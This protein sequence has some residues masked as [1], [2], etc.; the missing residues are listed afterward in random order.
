MR[1]AGFKYLQRHWFQCQKIYYHGGSPRLTAS[2]AG[3]P[4]SL[5]L[6]TLD[7][8]WQTRWAKATEQLTAPHATQ[9]QKCYVLPM[10]PYPSGNLHMGHLRVYTISDVLARCRRMQGYNVLHPIGWDAFGLPAENAAVERGVD[11]AEWTKQNIRKMKEQLCAMGV[12]FDWSREFMTCDPSFYQHTQRIFLLLHERGLAYQAESLVNYDPID[13]TV[14]ANEQVDAAGFSWRSGAKVEKIMLK[15]WFLKITDF[16]EKL[17]RDLDI[18]A[19]DNRWPERVLSMQR[20][21]LGKSEGAR[22]RF[23]VSRQGIYEQAN[24]TIEAFTTRPDTLFGV[25]YLAVSSTHPIAASLVEKH[26]DLK[27]FIDAIPSLPADSKAGFL[28]PG[29]FATNP[30]S[31]SDSSPDAVKAPLPIYVAPYV[32][33]DYGDGAVMGVPGHDIRDHAFWRQ[34]RGDEDIRIVVEPAKDATTGQDDVSGARPNDEVFVHHGVLTARCGDLIGIPSIEAAQKIVSLLSQAGEYAIRAESWRLRDWLISRQRYWGTPIPMVH[35]QQCG[36]VPVPAEDLPVELPKLDGDW[37]RGKGGNPLESA[38]EWV[39]TACPKC[40]EGAKRDT[41]TMDTFVDSSWYFMRFPDP[42]NATAA[43][44]PSAAE[45]FLPVDIYVGGVEHA[46]LH[47][48]YARFL[49]K[50]IATTP[51][52]PSGG[53]LDNNGEPFQKLISQG[54]VHGKTYSDPDTG[55]FLKPAEVDLQDNANPRIFKTGEPPN[56]SWE[57]MSKSK[58]NGVDPTVCIKKYGADATRAHILFQAPVTEVL[59][60]DEERIVGVQRWFGRIWRL[61]HAAQQALPEATASLRTPT[62]ERTSPPLPPI[63]TLTDSEAHIWAE[64]Q[65]TISS[66]TTSLTKTF[67]LNTLISDLMNLTNVL[68][69]ASPSP[70]PALLHHATSAILRMLA[71]VAP[72]V[73]EECWEHLHSP[74]ARTSNAQR[75]Q[76]ILTAPFPLPDRSLHTHQRTRQTCVVQENGKLRFAIDIHLPPARLFSSPSSAQAKDAGGER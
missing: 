37:F 40:G 58:Y 21:W 44:A 11:P 52:W 10:F 25:Q 72:A 76:S 28:L 38:A 32:L 75:V 57:K 71:P 47:L 59:E 24:F 30:L 5:D 16:K 26:S 53:G 64:T 8:K 36:A 35:C 63:L 55:R 13:R 69:S 66:V 48:L 42:H 1:P 56:V 12:S 61:A 6:L 49:A 3:A 43:F 23:P 51:L 68:S 62:G 4:P 65:R 33:G 29:V 46:I 7:A 67:T 9:K 50:F 60:W 31:Y 19:K 18:L 2:T 27:A 20:N 41:D 39:N 15:Q 74:Q 73:A 34:N 54:M 45:A 70:N 17:L 22:I 14:L